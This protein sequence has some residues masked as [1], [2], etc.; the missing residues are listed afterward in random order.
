MKNMCFS[1]QIKWLLI[2]SEVDEEEDDSVEA[3]PDKFLFAICLS[4]AGAAYELRRCERRG[5]ES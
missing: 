1:R 3:E 5:S 4:G 2:R